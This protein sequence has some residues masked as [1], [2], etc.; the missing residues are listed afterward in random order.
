MQYNYLITTML[1]AI[2]FALAISVIVCDLAPKD[3][4]NADYLAWKA[5]HGIK[6]DATED[7][8]RMFLFRQKSAEIQAHNQNP[9]NTYKKGHNQFSCLCLASTFPLPN[10]KP[11]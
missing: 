3:A 7:R 1:K 6:Y 5:K 2:L 8:Y 11:K 9:K 4:D 10:V